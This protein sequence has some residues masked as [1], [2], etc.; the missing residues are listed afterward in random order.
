MG[1]HELI[2][3]QI[4]TGTLDNTSSKERVAVA[5]TEGRTGLLRDFAST[6]IALIGGVIAIFTVDKEIAR[7]PEVLI[8]GAVIIG[9]ATICAFVLRRMQ[10]EYLYE[11]LGILITERASILSASRAY[12]R[13]PDEANTEA[14]LKSLEQ[15]EFPD[16]NSLKEFGDKYTGIV[17]LTGVI[18]AI[19]GLFL[20]I[21]L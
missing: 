15:N 2:A 14:F 3:Q 9:I 7:T 21:Q 13:N 8:L 19:L 16:R 6:G 5:M 1:E 18:I 12:S 4:T 11:V 10:N 20:Q 17:M